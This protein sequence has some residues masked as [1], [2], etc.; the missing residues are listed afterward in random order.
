LQELEAGG[1]VPEWL[2]RAA[3]ELL[4]Q[5]AGSPEYRGARLASGDG[6]ASA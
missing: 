6:A 5:G 4:G 2:R 3:A 1:A